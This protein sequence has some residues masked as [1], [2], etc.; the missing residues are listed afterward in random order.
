LDLPTG[1]GKTAALDIALFHLAL[2]AH[3][4]DRH[5]PTRIVFVVDR[6]TIVDQATRRAAR[7]RQ[8]LREPPGQGIVRVVA[9]RLSEI[10][11]SRDP[12]EVAVLRGGI[13]RGDAWARSPDQPLIVLSTVD[14]VGS[15]LLFR[16]YGVS[17]SMRPVHAG[18][19]G[20]DALYLLDE[21][22]LSQPFCESL[23]AVEKFRSWCDA[24]LPERWQ[25][26]RMSATPGDSA[27]E[28]F[29]LDEADREC[30]VLKR[31]L[32]AGKGV[33]LESVAV[34]GG[35]DARR[36]KFA[37]ACAAAASGGEGAVAVAVVVN[38]VLSAREV[39]EVLRTL[40]GDERRVVLLTG[41][42]RPIERQLVEETILPHVASGRDRATAEPIVVVATQCI[43]AGAD[44]DFDHLVSECASLDALLQRF[45]R[46]NR[47]GDQ[48]QRSGAVLVRSDSLGAEDDPIY[49]SALR[50]TWEYLSDLER[51]DFGIEGFVLPD[52]ERLSA[53]VPNRL[54]SPVMLPAHL[55]AWVQTSPRPR[56]DPDA[57]L[58][59][60]G[61][62]DVTAEV[63]IV[64]RSD[65]TPE[66]MAAAATAEDGEQAEAIVKRR[67]EIS[68]PSSGE[69]MSVAIGVARRWLAGAGGA[70][71]DMADV[72]G[73]SLAREPD[74]DSMGGRAALAWRGERSEIVSTGGRGGRI[75]PGDTLVVPS[76]YGGI[77]HANWSEGA[78]T[79]VSD[80]GDVA[81]FAQRG[82]PVL[83]LDRAVLEGYWEEIGDVPA[84]ILDIA[85]GDPQD[86]ETD[87]DRVVEQWL[88][89]A[90][91][92]VADLPAALAEIVRA[93]TPSGKKSRYRVSRI[94]GCGDH[95]PDYLVI[96]GRRIVV[97]L[98]GDATTEDE[99]S[100]FSG[101]AVPLR[102]HLAG[103]GDF[104]GDFARRCGLP[105]ELVA[106]LA[107][108]GRWHDAGK[109]DPR[110]QRMLHGGSE[111]KALVAEEPL[112]KSG[113]PPGDRAA[114]RLARER[115]GYPVGG[116]HELASLKLM[117]SC[118][119]LR[120][121]AGVDVELALYLVAAHHGHC[122]PL[123]PIAPDE[124]PVGID[125]E[126]ELG[127]LHTTSEHGYERL[128]SGVCDRFWTMVGRYGWFGLAWL[129]AIL[130]LADHRRS[131][132]EQFL[133]LD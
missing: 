132:A 30:E 26:V 131:E 58:W 70:L 31:R 108:A 34:H 6:R 123:A 29:S 72:E 25:V 33:A 112:A 118:D 37:K 115:S 97:R 32:T 65:L 79:P 75:R 1:T 105:A 93:L 82:R 19:L 119:A 73:A 51:P 128:D 60:H 28:R 7:L 129:E 55:D 47:L 56:P 130:R 61:V 41:R 62:K 100:C 124:D 77:D 120:D 13:P 116:R 39:F 22:H 91:E 78:R 121:V 86:P 99:T 102:E 103:V 80:L 113:L 14:Q 126:S 12:L 84:W 57:S 89:R 38:R 59:L 21:V 98:A 133:Q 9:E 16:G 87:D 104:S 83:R 3:S 68:P 23:D 50:A 109:A 110:F 40:A 45:G 2:D 90:R 36:K 96:E 20:N 114:R 4:S 66:L 54:H 44:Y 111:F 117:E 5:A 35:E 71:E 85:P 125:F 122:R 53:L 15:R 49:G 107:L 94:P 92:A 18:L 17:D 64:W 127:P 88:A 67:V 52:A 69:A 48:R 10:G 42:M 74:V 63:Q 43:E 46:L 8:V 11:R 27:G 24:G 106:T 76:R 101:V 81:S 95:T